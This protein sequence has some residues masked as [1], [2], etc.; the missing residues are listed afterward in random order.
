MAILTIELKHAKARKL[1][2]ELE[3][4]N[5]IKMLDSTKLNNNKKPSQLRGALS[6]K[7]AGSLLKHITKTR[8]EWSAR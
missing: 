4:M 6:K 5:I 3:D 8:E 2:Q 7:T 1:L